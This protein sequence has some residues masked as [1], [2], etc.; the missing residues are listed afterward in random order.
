LQQALGGF[1]TS[2]LVAVSIFG[3]IGA[4]LYRVAQH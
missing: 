3:L 2:N 1:T 4:V